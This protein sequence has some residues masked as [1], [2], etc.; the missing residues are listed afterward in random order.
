MV[1]GDEMS[2]A[3]DDANIG[4]SMAI[5]GLLDGVKYFLWGLEEPSYV[6]KMMATG[7]R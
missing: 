4:L 3:F 1:P 2:Q 5:L 6:M 7:V